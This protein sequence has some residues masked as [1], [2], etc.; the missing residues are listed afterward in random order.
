MNNRVATCAL[1]A[2]RHHGLTRSLR[3]LLE[4]TFGT[5]FIVAD[6][7]S[8]IEGAQ[9][10]NPTVVIVDLSLTGDDAI[11]LLRRLRATAPETQVVTLCVEDEPAVARSALAAGADAVVLK[12]AIAT[13]L[14]PALDKVMAAERYVSPA[15]QLATY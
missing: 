9:R 2:D 8:L 7:S 12:R 14:L 13:D 3:D 1:L 11:A 6:E 4:T 5:V 10:L 15:I